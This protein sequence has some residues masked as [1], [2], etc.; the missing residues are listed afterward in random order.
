MAVP[1]PTLFPQEKSCRSDKVQRPLCIYPSAGPATP[2]S[3]PEYCNHKPQ[4]PSS[5]SSNAYLIIPYEAKTASSHSTKGEDR[6]QDQPV[7]SLIPQGNTGPPLSPLVISAGQFLV[8]LFSEALLEPFL[9]A[10]TGHGS[11]QHD[12]TEAGLPGSPGIFQ[13]KGQVRT[14]SSGPNFG[15][16]C[17]RIHI[18]WWVK[19]LVT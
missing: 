17:Q 14:V 3:F 9:K 2:A 11:S 16:S 1:I 4:F 18:L 15:Q 5:V 8:P 12:Q 13:A 7:T 6:H 10:E 19:S